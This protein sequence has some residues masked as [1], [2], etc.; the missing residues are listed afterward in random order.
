MSKPSNLIIRYIDLKLI[1]VNKL[2]S[3]CKIKQRMNA[4]LKNVNLLLSVSADIEDY[5]N[6]INS[7]RNF[8]ILQ[9]S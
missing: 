1:L 8:E 2:Q 4:K 9:T 7:E 3:K 5:L 6:K